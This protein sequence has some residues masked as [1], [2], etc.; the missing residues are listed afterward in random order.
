MNDATSEVDF[1]QLLEILLQLAGKY[2]L[3]PQF[4]EREM[5]ST[6]TGEQVYEFQSHRIFLLSGYYCLLKHTKLEIFTDILA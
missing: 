6:K 4:L 2:T 3:V 1:V 5:E